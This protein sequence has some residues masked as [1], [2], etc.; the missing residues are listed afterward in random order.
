MLMTEGGDLDKLG[1]G[2]IW[3][4]QIPDCL[5]QNH[6]FRVRPKPELLDS[7]FFA[8]VVESDIAKSYFN[9]VAKRTTNLASTNKTQVRAFRFPVPPTLAEQRQIVSVMKA[10][11]ATIAA[12]AM[13]A[14]ALETLKK[15]VMHDLLTGRVRV[16]DTSRLGF[17]NQRLARPRVRR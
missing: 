1:R 15:S 14:A 9:Q 4:R 16:R 8:L 3:E 5:H 6:I 17:T 7:A 10:S 2:T 12:L 11:K 13:K